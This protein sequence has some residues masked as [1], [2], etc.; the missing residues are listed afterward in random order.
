MLV[1]LATFRTALPAAYFAPVTGLPPRP[2]IGPAPAD[3]G[4]ELLAAALVIRTGNDQNAVYGITPDAAAAVAS[5][6]WAPSSAQT[7]VRGLLPLLTADHADLPP[8]DPALLIAVADM[9]LR[10]GHSL[11]SSHF[12]RASLPHALKTGDVHSWLRLV[13]LGLQAATSAG[14]DGDLEYF[15]RED[16]TRLRLQG[17][18]IALAAVLGATGREQTAR[19]SRSNP[20]EVRYRSLGQASSSVHGPTSGI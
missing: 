4:A 17:D 18:E 7:A 5:L 14:H 16:R 3:A 19:N 8:P 15:S 11:Q 1:A 9:L 20:T 6:G 12:I 10:A 2:A 13:P